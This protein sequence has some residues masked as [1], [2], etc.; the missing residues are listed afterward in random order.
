MWPKN[1]SGIY[2]GLTNINYAIE[3]SIN[4]V[5]VR[6]LE[7]VGIN[8]SFDFLYNDL[9]F[10]SLIEVGNDKDGNI[11]TDK[12]VAALAL[13]QF[14]YG[15]TL[16]ET[17][18]AYSIFANH[19]IYNDYRSYY[20]VT[21]INSEVVLSKEYNGEAVLSEENADIMTMMLQNVV[22]N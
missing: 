6:V 17:T 19:G 1:A 10:K 8:E 15:V 20:K 12:D 5:S 4:T 18:A 14:N 21:D 9:G 2:R 13:G 3:N 11:I 16:R 7:D 22:T